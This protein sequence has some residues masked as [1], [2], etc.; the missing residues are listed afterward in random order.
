MIFVDTGALVGRYV[1]RDQH[2]AESV[3]GWKK[4]GDDNLSFCTS[5]LVIAEALTLI[6]RKAD[7]HFAVET[8][9]RIYSANAMK[10]LRSDA[11]DENAAVG[12]LEKYSDQKV[13][14]TDCVSFAIMRKHRIHHVF[15]FDHHFQA[16]GFTLWNRR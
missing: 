16:A 11:A 7:Y 13:S 6:G 1:L 10:I 8:G 15:G 12:F 2:H 4:I 5:N 14:F 9:R 3:T